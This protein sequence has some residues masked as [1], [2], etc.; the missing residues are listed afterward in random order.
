[1]SLKSFSRRDGLRLLGAT[2]A[3]ALAPVGAQAAPVAKLLVHRSPT[4][5]CCGAW[6]ERLRTAG[7]SVEVVNEANMDPIKARLGVPAALASC[8]TAEID[9]Y[10]IEGHVPAEAIERLLKERPKTIGLAAPGM[11]AGSPGMET[12]G[13]S[14]PYMLYLFDA[15]GSREFGRYFGDKSF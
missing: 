15:S 5:G 3:A 12:G 9:G 13:E 1:M 10:V 8:H 2:C 11:P 4:C 6:V 7:Y 14:E